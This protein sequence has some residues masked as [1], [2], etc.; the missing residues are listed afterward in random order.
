MSE[1]L[2]NG[3]HFPN[4]MNLRENLAT[5][6][7]QPPYG[8]LPFALSNF[9]LETVSKKNF[10]LWRISVTCF[11][12]VQGLAAM[13]VGNKSV[14]L[15]SVN[16]NNNAKNYTLGRARQFVYDITY[17]IIFI[18]NDLPFRNR[19]ITLYHRVS[20]IMLP[21]KSFFSSSSSI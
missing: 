18:K 1:Q 5:Q 16:I 4:T 3:G 2:D 6:E 15:A 17:L 11:H 8:Y 7:Y 10:P 14:W 21:M 13:L 9:K 19:L 12:W 20:A